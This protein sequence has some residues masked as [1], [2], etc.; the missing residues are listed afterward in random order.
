MSPCKLREDWTFVK[1]NAFRW[2]GFGLELDPITD[3]WF[4]FQSPQIVL[5]VAMYIRQP[6]IYYL[7]TNHELWL[8]YQCRSTD[9]HYEYVLNHVFYWIV[10][11]YGSYRGNHRCVCSLFVYLPIWDPYHSFLPLFWRLRSRQYHKWRPRVFTSSICEDDLQTSPEKCSY[12]I[13][14]LCSWPRNYKGTSAYLQGLLGTIYRVD[15]TVRSLD[16]K[17]N[18]ALCKDCTFSRPGLLFRNWNMDHLTGRFLILKSRL[19]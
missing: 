14:I 4:F 6:V 11:S 17:I 15:E 8:P 3:S 12:P 2:L 9:W 16:D 18:T 19:M 13:G 7:V 1:Q 10:L 5:H